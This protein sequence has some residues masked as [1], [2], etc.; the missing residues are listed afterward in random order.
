MNQG[1]SIGLDLDGV[2]TVKGYPAREEGWKRT[3]FDIPEYEELYIISARPP[4]LKEETKEWLENKN[5]EY[6]ELIMSSIPFDNMM[7]IVNKFNLNDNETWVRAVSGFSVVFK[8]SHINNLELDE[9]YEDREKV[10]NAL[11]KVCPNT[12]IF[13]VNI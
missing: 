3:D 6:T 12:E 4:T 8:A 13:L 7:S 10:A 1:E 9:Y 11:S 5:I 2:L